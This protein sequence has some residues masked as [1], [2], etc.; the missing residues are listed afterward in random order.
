MITESDEMTLI[1]QMIAPAFG[2]WEFDAMS[3]EIPFELSAQLKHAPA[4]ITFVRLHF[5][6]GSIHWRA[7]P[8][9]S[10]FALLAAAG[11]GM[12]L[13]VPSQVAKGLR[14]NIFDK[15]RSWVP[16]AERS[17]APNSL[18]LWR[19]LGSATGTQIVKLIFA[20]ALILHFQGGLGQLRHE[21]RRL[22]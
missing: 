22:R 12:L 20:Q 11:I 19:P 5:R 16:G 15:N 4:E 10:T 8:E 2:T 14:K 1:G 6:P 9:P 7:I 3:M 18:L 17:E 21:K 13:L